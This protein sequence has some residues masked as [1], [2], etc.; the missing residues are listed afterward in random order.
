MW[1]KEFAKRKSQGFT[2]VGLALDAEGIEPA[3][4]YYDR[5]GVKFPSL[6]DPNYA[7]KFTAVPKTFFVDE[8]GVVRKLIRGDN[9]KKLIRPADKLKPVTADIRSQW[10][11]PGSRI[12][13]AAI[14]R[15]EKAVAANPN[16]LKAAVQLASRYLDLKK[17]ASAC[18]VLEKTIKLFDAKQVA[19][20]EAKEQQELLGQA[21]FQLSRASAGNR[22]A[23]VTYATLSY[24]LAPSIGYGKQIARIIAPKKF[25]NRP[26][27]DFD[28]RFREGTL[29]RL[30][31]ERQEWLRKD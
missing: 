9:W 4:L 2:L 22:R 30:R 27:G 12:K 5:Y 19:R 29:Q 24:Y 31:R 20:G 16:D 13:P 15:L 14:A 11:K 18:E 10:S 8:H 25:D 3:K 23:Q 21:Y 17:P 7:T 26:R 1:Q 28:N 6:V